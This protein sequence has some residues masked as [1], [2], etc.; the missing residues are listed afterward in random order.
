MN[1]Q[2]MT[3]LEILEAMASGILPHPS[4]ATTI[5][6]KLSLVEKGKV[7]F[8]AT[9]NNMHHNPLGGVHGGFAAT[10]LDSATGCAVHTVLGAGI[11]YSTIDLCVKMLRPVPSDE[12][13]TAEGVV[14]NISKSLGISEATLK[15]ENGKIL[16]S[17]TAT[18]LIMR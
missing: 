2:K 12:M 8:Q 11:G 14:V 6:M 13:L 10:V 17:A 4:M 15:S 1:I 3:G 16:A 7:I 18:C 5:P 9:A